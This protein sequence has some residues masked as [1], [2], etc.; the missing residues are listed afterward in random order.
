VQWQ[1]E[2]PAEMLH[3]GRLIGSNK[4]RRCRT[5]SLCSLHDLASGPTLP[6]GRELYRK[7]QHMVEHPWPLKNKLP[8]GQQHFTKSELLEILEEVPDSEA[9]I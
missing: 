6:T 9:P 1:V 2:N 3:H 5:S 7:D 4:W 8:A